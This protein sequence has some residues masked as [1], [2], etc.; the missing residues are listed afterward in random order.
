MPAGTP[1]VEAQPTTSIRP[2]AATS[3]ESLNRCMVSPKI[4]Y[5]NWNLSKFDDELMTGF[6]QVEGAR[7]HHSV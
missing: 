2:E 6:D 4:E 3:D 7:M 1:C 5:A